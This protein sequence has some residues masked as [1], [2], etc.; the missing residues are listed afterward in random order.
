MSEGGALW[1]GETPLILASSSTIRRVLIESAG[2][3]LDVMPADI[4]ERALEYALG[5]RGP[6]EVAANLAMAKALAV[7]KTQPQRYVLGAD[8]TLELGGRQ[9]NKPASRR[10]AA[11][12]LVL[13]SG[14]SHHL[15]SAL[16][17]AINGHAVW[18]H[19]ETAT[20]HV[21]P[22]SGA[23]IHDYL[24]AAGEHVTRSV[25]A[26]QIEGLGMHLFNRIEG[27]H[28]TIMGLPV[29]PLFRQLR[30]MGLLAD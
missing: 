5:P 21:R 25:G 19:V 16:A 27:D 28:T 17:L 24:E 11:D 30:N 6:K 3:P 14:R 7:S 20:L 9:L 4:D 1:S 10:E 18:S 23:F 12:H 2:L 8:Q 29:L 13:M 22:L 15:H 26:Y